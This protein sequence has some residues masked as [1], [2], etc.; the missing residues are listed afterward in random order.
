MFTWRPVADMGYV[1][2]RK[3]HSSPSDFQG[4]TRRTGHA[5][6]PVLYEEQA[7]LSRTEPDSRG[8]EL[9]Q[10][11]ETSSPGPPSTSPSSV[12]LPHL[13]PKDLSPCPG[14]DY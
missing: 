4:P 10:R 12:A 13:V 5:E 3:L 8:N 11:K 2:G 1:T 14:G 9:V 7:S 6:T